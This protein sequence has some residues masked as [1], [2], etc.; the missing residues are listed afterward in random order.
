MRRI[1]AA[2]LAVL[3][4]N[5]HAQAYFFAKT[6]DNS[7]QSLFVD[8]KEGQACF[9]VYD[10]ESGQ[11]ELLNEKAV[12]RRGLIMTSIKQGYH[13]DLA[14][15]KGSYLDPDRV[16]E[17]TQPPL[18]AYEMPTDLLKNLQLNMNNWFFFL[19]KFSNIKSKVGHEI[20][21][22]EMKRVMHVVIESQSAKKG[23]SCLIRF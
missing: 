1:L 23:A 12:T 20:G 21:P 19:Q 3:I 5:G 9:F 2:A 16:V 4:W 10:S 14:S 22:S 15:D 13:Y 7:I 8:V 18:H 6:E 11:R 17:M